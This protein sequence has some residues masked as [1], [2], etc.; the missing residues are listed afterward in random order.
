MGDSLSAVTQ[1][2]KVPRNQLSSSTSCVHPVFSPALQCASSLMNIA[3]RMLTH[4]AE[5]E[6]R[7][8]GGEGAE[9]DAREK[10]TDGKAAVVNLQVCVC[11]L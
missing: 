11:V 5:Q 7:G 1:C 2:L 6:G 10:E 4:A 3:L 9:G 8:R